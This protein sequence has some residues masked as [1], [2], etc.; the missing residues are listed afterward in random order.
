M[1]VCAYLSNIVVLCSCNLC[2]NF[3]RETRYDETVMKNPVV[4]P[5]RRLVSLLLWAGFFVAIAGYFLH[6]QLLAW[7]QTLSDTVALRSVTESDGGAVLGDSNETEST[8]QVQGQVK[9]VASPEE[10]NSLV[11]RIKTV[12]KDTVSFVDALVT[13]SLQIDENLEVGGSSTT[14]GDSTIQGDITV[15]GEATFEGDTTTTGDS[16]TNGNSDVTGILTVGGEGIIEGDF[17]VEGEATVE[18]DLIVEGELTA[19]NVVYTITA[20]DGIAV[21]GTQDITITNDDL[22]SAQN[23][24][25]NVKVGSTTFSAASNTDT[26]TFEA[27]TGITLSTSGK[28]V[29]IAANGSA[30]NVSGWLSDTGKVYLGTSSDN[31]GIGTDSPTYKLHVVGTSYFSGNAT[32]AGGTVISNGINNSSGGITNAGP[33][34]GATGFTSS[35][36][37]TFSSLSTGILHSNVNGVVTSSALNLAGG[38]TEIT[39]TLPVTSGGTGLSSIASGGLIYASGANTLAVLG[40]GSDGEVLTISGGVPDWGVVPGSG[41]PC[42]TCLVTNP[43]SHQTITP[44]AV[45]ATGLII[46]QA[47]SGSVDVF[48]IESFDGTSTFFKVDSSG[49]VILGD[50]TTSGTFTVSPTDTDPISIDPVAEGSNPFTGTI[51]SQDLTAARTWTLPDLTGVFCL[52]T[53]NCSGTS[54]GIGGS[55]ATNYLTKWS[56]TY[57]VTQSVLYDDGTNIGLGT[58]VPTSK[59]HVAGTLRATGNTILNSDLYVAAH[60]TISGSLRVDQAVDFNNTFGVDGATTLGSTLDVTG[61]AT[62]G[63]NVGIGTA[64]PNNKLQVAGFINFNDT[65]FST[66]VGHNAGAL[67]DNNTTFGYGAGES[68]DGTSYHNV[69]VGYNALNNNTNG[70]RFVAIGYRALEMADGTEGSI[71]I[72]Y[73][74]LDSQ[75]NGDENIAI[76][77]SALQGLTSGIGNLVL[78]HNSGGSLNGD[79]NIVFGYSSGYNI[80]SGDNNIVFGYNTASNLTSG[81]NNMGLVTNNR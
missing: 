30:L 10:Q 6:P 59:L 81:S 29:T 70:G 40:A 18:E 54:A 27:S 4:R 64:S 65:V 71:A 17:T 74:A 72:G 14:A 35:G 9:G 21:S 60:A 76:G 43:A 79:Y 62:F 69:A 52:S 46:K 50:N 3:S 44:A 80:S 61:L 19:P 25:K 23:I 68:L 41:D 42:P 45:G 73:S 2:L 49:N 55:G 34:T 75:T 15:E 20:G 1:A 5:K 57:T 38:G 24:F 16:T 22:G 32:F 47:S 58:T 33:I 67:G 11:F 8:Q 78:G 53:G 39:G 51:T 77:E 36:T 13:G 63:G 7:K 31:V 26:M 56:N 48:R 37:I 12:F 66:G 28:T